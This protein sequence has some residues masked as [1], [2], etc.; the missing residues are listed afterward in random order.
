VA[1]AVF[2]AERRWNLRLNSGIDVRLPEDDADVALLRLVSLDRE[3]SLLSRDVT[4]ID[5][6]LPDRVAVRLSD[7][8]AQARDIAMKDRR[9][10]KGAN[11]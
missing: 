6:R 10:A 9:R 1:A 4:V 8:A 3:K 2:V 7:D 5:L 11:I